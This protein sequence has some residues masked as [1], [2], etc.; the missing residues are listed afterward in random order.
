M[1]FWQ[2]KERF[3]ASRSLINLE[4]CAGKLVWGE[5]RS[6][7]LNELVREDALREGSELGRSLSN[8]ALL[9][10]GSGKCA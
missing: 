8:E 7:L 2:G 9:E 5:A 1:I 4:Q 6:V 3:G 10:D